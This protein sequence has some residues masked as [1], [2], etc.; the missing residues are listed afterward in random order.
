K[1]WRSI[2]P[3][4]VGFVG[5][6]V[7]TMVAS[8]PSHHAVSCMASEA[9]AETTAIVTGTATPRSGLGEERMIASP[10]CGW[11]PGSG[12]WSGAI[13]VVRGAK[14]M[15]VVAEAESHHGVK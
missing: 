11:R 4:E 8:T 12:A 13:D 7:V 9:A 5:Q 15:K 2:R 10:S 1:C 14:I 6:R 3:I